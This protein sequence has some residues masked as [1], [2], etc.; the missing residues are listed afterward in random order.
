[1][2]YLCKRS[3]DVSMTSTLVWLN[4]IGIILNFFAG[5][6]IAPEL[7]GIQNIKNAEQVIER[8]LGNYSKSLLEIRDWISTLTKELVFLGIFSLGA[9]A[10][11]AYT[12]YDIYFK[13]HQNFQYDR[14][15][16]A[17]ATCV[18]MG[19]ISIGEFIK[20]Y[21][22]QFTLRYWFL[23]LV[24]FVL[25]LFVPFIAVI[26]YPLLLL[27]SAIVLSSHGIITVTLKLI[28][29]MT[30]KLE[31]DKKLQ[32]GLLSLGIVFL[33]LGNVLQLIATF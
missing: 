5:F 19:L 18:F 27:F 9:C 6:L 4:R 16:M 2:A 23:I 28:K 20:K 12:I 10:F 25:G 31:G 14:L 26:F 21:S 32:N 8:T 11:I 3:N 30:D 15:G 7:I 24:S 13:S 33:I 29:F 17:I 1:M 22:Y